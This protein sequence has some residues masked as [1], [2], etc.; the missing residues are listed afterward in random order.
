MKQSNTWKSVFLGAAFIFTLLFP[1]FHAVEH[2]N[3]E[4]A[5]ALC[6]HQKST[7]KNELTHQHAQLDSCAVCAFSLSPAQAQ[8]GFAFEPI[9]RAGS[10][11]IVVIPTTI[12]ANYSGSTLYLRG[13]PLC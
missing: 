10:T 3:E 1:A 7:Q 5:R 6:F 13:P 4:Q 9:L 12:L 2:F 8:A 11:K